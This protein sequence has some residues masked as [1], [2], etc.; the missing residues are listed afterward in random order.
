MSGVDSTRRASQA[1]GLDG[2][3]IEEPYLIEEPD[4]SLEPQMN[5]HSW[6]S[7]YKAA[8]EA[9]RLDSQLGLD[10]R[11]SLAPTVR[12]HCNSLLADRETP[13]RV[14]AR[15]YLLLSYIDADD[16]VALMIDANRILL[17]MKA[18]LGEEH[19]HCIALCLLVEPLLTLPD[20]ITAGD[21]S[22]RVSDQVETNILSDLL[23]EQLSELAGLDAF[24]QERRD[25]EDNRIFDERLQQDARLDGDK[26]MGVSQQE[27]PQA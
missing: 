11:R 1:I 13:R 2:Q 10:P 20:S 17:G 4:L 12:R 23:H 24:E 3:P 26:E 27:L 5:G 18:E 9:L 8:L 6:T 21:I 14:K 22:A 7:H 25:E 16:C 19:D 15:C